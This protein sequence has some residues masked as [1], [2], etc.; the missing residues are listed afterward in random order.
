M[1]EKTSADAGPAIRKLRLAKGWTLMDLSVHS[2]VPVSTLS[3]V[4]LGQTHTNYEKLVRIS[5]ALDVDLHGM[6]A[7]EFA[8]VSAPSGRRS[9]TR[10]GQGEPV[11]FHGLA[12]LAAGGE[13]LAK[14]FTPV[15]LD[16]ATGAPA[17]LYAIDREAYLHVLTGAVELRSE[18]YAPLTL[19]SGDAVYFDGRAA[20]AI[21][22][23]DAK[24]AR[25]LLVI[26]GQL[27]ADE[28]GARRPH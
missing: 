19:V 9:V 18:L 17:D 7:R 1:T 27:S 10:A 21:S 6:L 3:R 23:A 8:G 2:G 22:T 28:P 16:V 5:R 14:S 24:G 15:I 12:G 25:V 13:L 4:E 26:E 20:H 11:A